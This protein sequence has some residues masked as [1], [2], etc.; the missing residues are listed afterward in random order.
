MIKLHNESKEVN[1]MK[2]NIKI[3]HNNQI[4][5]GYW[6]N[7]IYFTKNKNFRKFYINGK[8]IL[9]PTK[10]YIDIKLALNKNAIDYETYK[11]IDNNKIQTFDLDEFIEYKERE[12][13]EKEVQ[14]L[15]ELTKIKE[16]EFK[17]KWNIKEEK[18][19]KNN[20]TYLNF[21]K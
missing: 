19:I 10:L 6:N 4:I 17:E 21:E 16:K 14:E 13:K 12:L 1:N 11:N 20:K 18:E 3:K 15:K 2:G 5:E 7:E 9:F 8:E